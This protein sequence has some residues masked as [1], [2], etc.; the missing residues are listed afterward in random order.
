MKKKT[1]VRFSKP[2]S[3]EELK[4]AAEGVTLLTVMS[5]LYGIS[6]LG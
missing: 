3:V 4:E 2:V 1:N 5:G 6:V